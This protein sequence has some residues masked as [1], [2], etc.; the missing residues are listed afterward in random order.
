MAAYSR[1]AL[2][3]GLVPFSKRPPPFRIEIDTSTCI[4]YKGPECG[5]CFNLC[6]AEDEQP[7]RAASRGRPEFSGEGCSGCGACVAACLTYPSALSL[8]RNDTP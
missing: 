5:A 3:R 4:V 1:R 7:L 2:L 8:V 6:P